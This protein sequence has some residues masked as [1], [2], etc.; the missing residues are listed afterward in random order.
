[1]SS[2]PPRG[3]PKAELLEALRR[4]GLERLWPAVRERFEHLGGARGTVRLHDATPEER[5][6]VAALLALPRLPPE[7]DLR[8]SLDR[9]DRT[10]EDSRFRISL[11]EALVALGGPLRD[12]P[13]ERERRQRRRRKMWE[14]ARG[15]P[16]VAGR[17]ELRD[18]L[19]ELRGEGLLRR[20]AG[21][22]GEERQL[23]ERA[24]A[25][26]AALPSLGTSPA[27]SSASSP[28]AGS[29]TEGGPGIDSVRLPVLANRVLGS[30]H[31]LD[32]GKPVATLVLRALARLQERES[33]GSRAER[34]QL[35]R[36]QLSHRQLWRRAGVITDELSSTVLVLGLRPEGGGAVGE[37]LRLL[38]AAGEP[39]HLTLRQLLAPAS[40][41]PGLRFPATRVHV[42]ENPVVVSAAADRWG[43]DS[44]PLVCSSGQLHHA[45]R[46]LLELLAE[47]G[48]EVRYHG[49]FDWEGLRIA[50]SVARTVPFVPWRFT[51]EDYRTAVAAMAGEAAGETTG[52]PL[53][54]PPAEAP[55]DPELPAAMAELGV[56]V[57][58]ERVLESLLGDLRVGGGR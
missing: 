46:R 11:E 44:A 18:W 52:R 19:G 42:C 15:H 6:T 38:A 53:E 37:A 49:D 54:G 10:L 14:E 56:V 34:R 55:W 12:R 8:V 51:A 7:G 47:G 30:S 1:M 17:P 24:L 39:V 16:L 48:S 28:A 40:D 35:D 9:L 57:E 22:P 31:A 50:A 4:P 26:L 5:R 43:A 32:P 33:T 3:R 21:D 13:A 20:L 36:G 2:D 25:V 23:L 27:S 58:E 41:A 29:E 45:G